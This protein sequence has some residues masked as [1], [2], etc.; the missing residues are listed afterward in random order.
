MFQNARNTNSVG[1]DVLEDIRNVLSNNE[2]SS[3][4]RLAAAKLLLHA[5][6]ILGKEAFTHHISVDWIVLTAILEA[7]REEFSVKVIRTWITLFERRRVSDS[8]DEAVFLAGLAKYLSKKG[9]DLV[10]SLA[11]EEA[12]KLRRYLLLTF[13]ILSELERGAKLFENAIHF[14]AKTVTKEEKVVS[15]QNRILTITTFTV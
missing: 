6:H 14:V 4:T 13:V 15:D 9:E 7:G 12:K 11:V 3:N 5:E 8:D 2:F 10:S 1:T